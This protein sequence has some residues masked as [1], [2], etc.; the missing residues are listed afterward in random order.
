MIRCCLLAASLLLAVAAVAGAQSSDATTHLT[1][2]VYPH[3][4]SDPL[5]R[6]YR[7]ACNPAAG[8]VPRPGRACRALAA[9]SSP[10]APVPPHTVCAQLVAGLQEA[11]VRGVVRGR[12]V[13]ARLSLQS[14][15]ETERWRR[16]AAIV[17][18]F[19]SG[20]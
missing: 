12:R 6:R 10:F 9:I 14:S 13:D 5:V 4:T 2:S 19:P 18:G 3:G 20:A 8:T 17:P 11:V 16:V 1:I 15:C 7:L